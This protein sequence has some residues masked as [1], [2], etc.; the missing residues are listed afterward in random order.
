MNISSKEILIETIRKASPALERGL[1]EQQVDEY[2]KAERVI[3]ENIIR[4]VFKTAGHG[5]GVDI[6]LYATSDEHRI[7]LKGKL[8]SMGYINMRSFVPLVDDGNGGSKPDPRPNRK[9]AIHAFN[10]HIFAHTKLA[11]KLLAITDNMLGDLVEYAIYK[12]AY[13][14]PP[15]VQYGF[16]TREQAIGVQ[17]ILKLQAIGLQKVCS[18]REVPDVL[19]AEDVRVI[20]DG[21]DMWK[22][23]VSVCSSEHA[24]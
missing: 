7:A 21:I 1:S 9:F 22:V 23:I 15:T 4:E 14:Y 10:T 18:E 20:Q 2:F 8:K 16:E 17:N 6:T 13:T 19:R 24:H 12:S 11:E 5:S 3:E